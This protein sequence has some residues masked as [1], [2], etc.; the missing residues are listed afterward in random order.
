MDVVASNHSEQ[1][2]KWLAYGWVTGLIGL[3]VLQP[4]LG[5][6]TIYFGIRASRAAKADGDSRKKKAQ[7]LI[8]LGCF[9]FVFLLIIVIGTV[10]L[11]GERP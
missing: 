4:I 5:S 11:I 6:I 3:V 9:D 1:I 8:A 7:A 10:R 2:T